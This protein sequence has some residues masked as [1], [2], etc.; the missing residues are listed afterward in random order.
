[1]SFGIHPAFLIAGLG[2]LIALAMIF[3]A[4]KA[5]SGLATGL[6]LFSA[7]VL[8]LPAIYLFLDFHPELF[9]ARFRTHKAFYRDI[10]VGMTRD[11]VLA[12][13]ET[14]YPQNGKRQRPKILE[15]EP[16]KLSFLMN[17]ERS[18]RPHLEAIYLSLQN[19]RVISKDYSP[20]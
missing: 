6:L 18:S 9:D 14:R 3:F 20:D 16:G 8:T 17:R 15:N 5:R 2:L 19:G 1:M 10:Q 7:L 11:Q 4:C 13:M 12:A